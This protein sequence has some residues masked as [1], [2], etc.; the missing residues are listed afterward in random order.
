MVAP[1]DGKVKLETNKAFAWMQCHPRTAWYLF[2]VGF[3]NIGL[4]LAQIFLS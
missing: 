2:G 4:N 1:K 3:I